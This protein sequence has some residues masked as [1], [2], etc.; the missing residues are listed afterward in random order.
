MYSTG[1][2]FSGSDSCLPM[3]LR[4][5]LFP[6]VGHQAE[7]ERLLICMPWVANRD[8]EVS[9]ATWMACFAD[10]DLLA[11]ATPYKVGN[12]SCA[13]APAPAVVQP[14]ASQ[15]LEGVNLSVHCSGKKCGLWPLPS[16][17]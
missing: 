5:A 17:E 4:W 13:E 7:A 2:R 10:M 6:L 15:L 1:T 8:V 12:E 11:H 3:F 9:L 16:T 14:V